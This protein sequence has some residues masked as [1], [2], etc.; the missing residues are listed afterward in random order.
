MLHNSVYVSLNGNP[1]SAPPAGSLTEL[2]R[3][4]RRG[5]HSASSSFR[6]NMAAKCA[7]PFD[8]DK[9]AAFFKLSADC[10]ALLKK[11]ELTEPELLEDLTHDE[12]Y[13]LQL[14]LGQ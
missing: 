3:S 12:I 5:R 1:R 10:L 9:W 6:V 8:F 14:S 2:P 11:E 7:E 4:A 13:G